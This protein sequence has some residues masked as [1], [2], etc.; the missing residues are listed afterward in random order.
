[1]VDGICEKSF[2]FNVARMAGIPEEI[3]EAAQHIA[4]Q[5]RE[6]SHF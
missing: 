5:H 6:H 1:M 4:R 3:I 2:A